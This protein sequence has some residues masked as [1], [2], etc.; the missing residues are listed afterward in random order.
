[1]APGNFGYSVLRSTV[2]SEFYTELLDTCR[3]LDIE[4]EGLH[5]ETGPG[6]LEA[7]IAVAEACDAADKAALF[8]TFTKIMAQR[9]G[10][11]ATFM[12]KPLL[13]QPGN[14]LH[15]HISVVDDE[16]KN[17][18]DAGDKPDRRLLYAIGGLLDT[19]PAAMS[20]WAPNINSYRRYSSGANCAPVGVSW[21][22]ENRTVAF[23]IPQAKD[24]AWRVENRVP[25][26]DANPYLAMAVSLARIPTLL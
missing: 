22:H 11:M 20:F 10:M 6:V 21:G 7:A 14:G 2:Q 19:M 17:I 3:A 16:G 18:F 1:M 5:E 12:A 4:I 24:G 13:D 23:R 8:K 9:M 15:M 26:A 25:G